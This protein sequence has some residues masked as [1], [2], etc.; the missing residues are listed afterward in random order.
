MNAIILAGGKGT[1]LAPYTTILPKPLLPVGG[2][3]ILEIIIRQLCY[4][5]FN[6]ITL[7]VG[8]L[9][10]LIYA[11]FQ[12]YQ[13]KHKDVEISY[14]KEKQPLGTAGPVALIKDIKGHFLVMNGDVLTTL[15]YRRLM[16]FHGKS[17]ALLTIAVNK[18]EIR[19]E[20][21]VVV[22]NDKY[23]VSDYIE[24]PM[25][26]YFDS[27]GIYAYSAGVLKYIEKEVHLDLPALVKRIIAAGEK[28]MCYLHDKPH[29]WID[30]GQHMDYQKANEEFEK[31]R[32]DFIPDERQ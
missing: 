25:N 30:M 7:S 23:E 29:F 10:E 19:Q 24:K 17:G 3:P 2:M 28:V 6:H 16:D 5:G 20:V 1:R 9:S 18:R 21:G 13:E 26:T 12:N 27:M 15:D 31:R 11:Y 32:A 4:Y 8:H 14:V 22:F